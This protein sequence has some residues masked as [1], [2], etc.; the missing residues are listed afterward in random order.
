MDNL[1]DLMVGTQIGKQHEYF[2]LAKNDIYKLV[3]FYVNYKDYDSTKLS[4]INTI[5]LFSPDLYQLNIVIQ[6]IITYGQSLFEL[7]LSNM[8]IQVNTYKSDYEQ[9]IEE[10]VEELSLFIK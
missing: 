7:Y 10:Y 8:K 5:K 3:D 9:Y 6:Y 2:Q 1:C 4:L